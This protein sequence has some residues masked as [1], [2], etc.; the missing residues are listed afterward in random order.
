MKT[1]QQLADELHVSKTAIRKKIRKLNIENS[2]H[3][4]G[5]KFL[6]NETQEVLIKNLFQEKESQTKTE[7]S[8]Q[9]DSELVRV[10]EKQL[11]EK[12]HIIDE[13]LNKLDQEQKLHAMTQQKLF[14]LEDKSA[15]QKKGLF[16]WFRKE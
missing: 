13:L 8:T 12:Q 11:D 10:L 4:D 3:K 1:I 9:T 14:A 7:T 15:E 5:N 16:S 6:I 2:L